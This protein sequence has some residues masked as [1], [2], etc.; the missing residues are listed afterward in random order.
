MNGFMERGQGS[1]EY[2]LLLAAAVVVVGVVVAFIISTIGP[3]QDTGSQQTY[4]YTC[5][6]L[7]TNSF[8]CGC[9][10]CNLNKG[11]YS[12]E[13]KITKM[14]NKTDCDALSVYKNDSLLL[15]S[16]CSGW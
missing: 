12:P 2:L 5:K 4:D 15:G 13:L 11:G 16:K 3:V 10:E 7:D 6:T 14:A 8:L 9:Y 1:I